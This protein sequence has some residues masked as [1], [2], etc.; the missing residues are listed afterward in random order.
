M[1]RRRSTLTPGKAL[2][3]L[4][5]AAVLAGTAGVTVVNVL[6]QPVAGPTRAY[7]AEFT[8]ASGVQGDTQVRV[9]GLPVG[10]VDAVRVVRRGG[11]SLAEVDFRV[12]HRF[13]VTEHSR[14]AVRFAA[15]TGL[16]YLELIDPVDAESDGPPARIVTH[17]PTAMTLPSLD[18]TTLFNGMQP[19]L[20]TLSPEQINTFTDNVAT[21][22][23]GDGDGVGPMLA[24]IRT[25]TEFVT[26]RQSVI[27]TLMNNLSALSEATGGRSRELIQ[28]IDWANR[29]IDAA[30]Q[31]LDE[32]RKSALYGP[33][34]TGAL[35]RLLGN[36]GLRRG[37][38]LDDGLDRALT[39]FNDSIDGFKMV[40]VVWENIGPPSQAGDIVP[41]SRGPAQLPATMD[42]LLGGQRVVLC[43]P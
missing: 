30:M 19:V 15:L 39:N 20:A 26:D 27:A 17:L 16:R 22:L 33:E 21:L 9:R 6:G 35:A 11:Q 5:L 12:Q 23:S 4:L 3:R 24:S 7:T 1:T 42:V 38:D 36:L 37:A 14:V 18:V 40:P 13:A 43:N 10:K 31:V 25:L 28:L 2:L 34:F 32:F 29:P 41:C 8:D